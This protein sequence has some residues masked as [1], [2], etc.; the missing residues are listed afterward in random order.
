MN[1]M[2]TFPSYPVYFRP[3]PRKGHAVTTPA[4]HSR[5]EEYDADCGEYLACRRCLSVVT[6]GSERIEVQGAHTHS[7]TN[8][9][10]LFFDIGCF[11]HAPGCSYASD[12]SYEFTWFAGFRWQVAVCR[13]C[14]EHLGWLFTSGGSRFNGLILDKIVSVQSGPSAPRTDA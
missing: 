4:V 5:P 14:M 2:M 13:G 9:H 8:P 7:F 6:V 10:G 1:T 11:R 3:E 12:A